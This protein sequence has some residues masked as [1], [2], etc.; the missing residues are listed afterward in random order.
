VPYAALTGL[1]ESLA[2]KTKQSYVFGGQRLIEPDGRRYAPDYIDDNIVVELPVL[3]SVWTHSQIA[4]HFDI[5]PAYSDTTTKD[6]IKLSFLGGGDPMILTTMLLLLQ[7]PSKF[8]ALESVGREVGLWRGKRQVFKE[9]HVV[10]LHLAR[11][12]KVRDMF[13]VTDRKT[14]TKHDVSGHWKHYNKSQG[15]NH[16]HPDQR[17]AW[18]PVGADRTL[19]GDYKRY[20]CPYCLQR[21]TWTEFFTTQGPGVSTHHYEVT[22]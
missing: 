10:K 5:V 13:H 1:S 18:E 12:Q 14:P 22:R 16:H 4:A 15:C 8:V 9:H 20:W 21:R 19:A 17:Q 3:P 7:Q 6:V 11:E 2:D